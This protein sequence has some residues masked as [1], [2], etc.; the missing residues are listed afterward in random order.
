MK[1]GKKILIIVIALILI[2]VIAY[3]IF[4]RKPK[5]DNTVVSGSPS[6]TPNP[7]PS[8]SGSTTVGGP[9]SAFP[10]KKG[11]TGENVRRLQIAL[12]LIDKNG[13]DISQDGIYGNQTYDKI[14][15]VLPTNAYN[16]GGEITETQLNKI[17]A[18]GN[19]SA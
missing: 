9:V 19:A 6:P 14:L 10:L 18:L 8:P 13:T 7:V 3:F 1:T 11:S 16:V 5:Q 12:N 2:A 4:F 17:I 15:T